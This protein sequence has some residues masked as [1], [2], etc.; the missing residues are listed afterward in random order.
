M[1]PARGIIGAAGLALWSATVGGDPSV[2]QEYCVACKSPDAVYRCQIVNMGPAQAQP[3][4]L[5]CVSTLAKEGKHASCA[6]KGG[7]VY[8][9]VG[10]LKRVDVLGKPAELPPGTP[11]P[12]E[13]YV[14]AEPKPVVDET[15]PPKTVEEALRRAKKS[16]DESAAN[17]GKSIT[18]GA[19]RTWNCLAS[20]FKGC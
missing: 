2:A 12:T 1:A 15:E 18:T 13:P 5:L 4:K 7:T 10:P 14:V 11:Q 3:I 17:A 20:F 9:C 8:D 19:Q 6:V 16:T